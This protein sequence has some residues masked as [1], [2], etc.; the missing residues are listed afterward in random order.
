LQ[1]LTHAAAVA[2]QLGS[3]ALWYN[4]KNPGPRPS[5]IH[6]GHGA[7]V[8]GLSAFEPRPLIRRPLQVKEIV[9]K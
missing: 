1:T 9:E 3:L 8:A 6:G 2:R 5:R 4:K 7:G